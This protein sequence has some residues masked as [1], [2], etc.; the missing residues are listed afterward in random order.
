[1]VAGWQRRTRGKTLLKLLGLVGV[2]ENK[3]VDEA[4]ASDLE[5]DVA[6]LL[7]LLYARGCEN[8]QQLYLPPTSLRFGSS[9]SIAAVQQ[10]LVAVHARGMCAAQQLRPDGDGRRTLG[11]LAAADLDELLDVGDFGRHFG[12]CCGSRSVNWSVGLG[13]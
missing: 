1:M 3:G 2:L 8:C 11:I 12:G 4:L 5:L 9:S 10:P 6:G 7:V 13:R